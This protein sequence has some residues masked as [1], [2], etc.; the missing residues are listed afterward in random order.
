[1]DPTNFHEHLIG[2][3]NLLPG[4]ARLVVVLDPGGK[5][6]LSD[7]VA[8]TQANISGHSWKVRRYDGNDLAFRREFNTSQVTLVWV[9]GSKVP[10]DQNQI[11]LTSLVD[12]LRRADEILDISLLGVLHT[13]F[14]NETWPGDPITE[15]EDIIRNQLGDFAQ[16]YKNM[17]PFL[18]KNTALSEH[19]IQAIVL[20]CLQPSIQPV[21][22]LFRVDSSVVLLKKYVTL[23]WSMDWD[24]AGLLLLQ[25]QAR[26]ASLLPLGDLQSWFG[27]EVQGLAQLLYFYRLFSLARIPNIIN[28]IRGLGLLN[29]DPDPL[30]FGL[31]QVMLLWEKD[32]S[33]RNRL[34]KNAES[35][36]D[37]ETFHRATSLLR[38]STK[39]WSKI[40]A[41]IESPA[42]LYSLIAKFTEDRIKEGTFDSFLEFW[43][44]NR[45][46]LLD[47]L[48]DI[49]SPYVAPLR[50]LACVLDE[51][52]NIHKCISRENVSPSTFDDLLKWYVQGRYYDLEYAHARAVMACSQIKEEN[53]C[54][55]IQ[56]SLER[57]REQIRKY[58]DL[59]DHV[60][61][62]Q[63]RRNWHTY[64]TSSNLSSSILR[65]FVERPR[66]TP[67]ERESLWLIIFDG[68]RFDTWEGVVKPRLQQI[69]EIKKESAYLCPLPSW[70]SIARTSITA[71]RTPDLWKGY[72]NNFTYNQSLLAGK[73][74]GLP[75]NQYQ[76]KLRFYS[77]MESDR[78]LSKFDRNRRYPYNVLIFNI[79]D[80]DLHKQR[81]HVGALNENIKSA[82]DRI[83][84]FLDGLIQ[85]DDTVIITSDHGFQELDPGYEIVVKESNKWQRVL[86]GG[87]HPV[88]FRFIRAEDPAENLPMGHVLVFEWKMPD[89]KFAVAIGRHWF[90]REASKNVVRYDHGG[91]SF[92]E[93]VV[94]GVKMQTIR[95]KKIDLRFEGLPFEIQADEGQPINV[96][97][98]IVNRGNQ[99]ATFDLSYSLDTDR[100]WQKLNAQISPNGT[101]D[102]TLVVNPVF[103]TDGKKTSKLTMTLTYLTI[104]GQIQVRRHDLPVK[105]LERKDVVQI[106]LGDLDDLDL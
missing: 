82:T 63:I 49:S 97:V 47:R 75:E 89:G 42:M 73:F 14:P 105:L 57:L 72:H 5:L 104:S 26:E 71:A 38:S 7:E 19:S 39:E 25:K 27:I 62:E 87:G 83:I 81:D 69:L 95:D 6:K 48:D 36:L 102:V 2:R 18:G 52:S 34:I 65:D 9:T 92:A 94:P 31:G 59:A 99:P 13:L 58:L 91:L 101:Y 12:I 29:F 37:L 22:F 70:T 98:N 90:Q 76:Q 15:F 21:E 30:E 3:L 43:K 74:F 51:T 35:D 80:D 53:L 17:K 85:N 60:L 23:A 4:A 40:F 56:T 24:E 100:I 20:A 55:L 106:S 10:K 68:M 66:L 78:I 84:N 93:M 44:N 64:S 16:S 46:V 86:E 54:Q 1:M 41:D 33:W 88:R 8:S 96:K 45:P 50:A 103:Q 28:Q 77:G 67:T 79:S 11:D 61:S 32:I